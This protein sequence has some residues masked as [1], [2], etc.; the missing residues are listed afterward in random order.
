M[1]KPSHTNATKDIMTRIFARTI[2]ATLRPSHAPFARACSTP[3][4]ALPSS[5]SIL[6]IEICDVVRGTSVSGT[7]SLEM[8]MEIGMDIRQDEITA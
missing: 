1:G 4:S 3:V 8:T 7:R 6:I 2:P 5:G